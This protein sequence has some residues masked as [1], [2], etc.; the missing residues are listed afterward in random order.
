[1]VVDETQ[2]VADRVV[3]LT[4]RRPGKEDLPAWGPGAHVDLHLGPDL[5][6]QYSLCGDPA[7]RDQWRIAVL[8]DR[9]AAA[10]LSGCTGCGPANPARSRAA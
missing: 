2:M 7:E 5:V 3:A 9:T 6:R 10:G 4:L 8:L 1:V